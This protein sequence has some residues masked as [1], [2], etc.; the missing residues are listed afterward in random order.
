MKN[1]A[2]HRIRCYGFVSYPVFSENSA[3]NDY[4]CR[5]VFR[6]KLRLLEVETVFCG[7]AK[8]FPY[9]YFGL[10]F[11]PKKATDK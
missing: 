1:E 11:A 9:P 4:L 3:K 6:E 2:E 8:V 5:E 7:Q 10:I